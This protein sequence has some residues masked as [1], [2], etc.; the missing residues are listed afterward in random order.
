MTIVIHRGFLAGFSVIV[1][2][3]GTTMGGIQEHNPFTFE[4]VWAMFQET[5]KQS[6]ETDRKFKE[7]D[8]KFQETDKKFRETAERFRETDKKFKETDKKF[9]EAAE[10]FRETDRV[11]RETSRE[12]K[13][14]SRRLE[15]SKRDLD[16]RMGDLGNRFGE[17]AEHLVAPSI[18]EKFNALGYHFD[19]I[20]PGGLVI[21]D[22]ATKQSL[23]EI[24]ILLQNTE[25][26]VAVEVKAKLLQ[27]HV[28][29]HV[30]RV[31]ALRAWA[32]GHNDRRRIHGAVAGAIVN[33]G[34]RGYA[35]RAGFYVIVQT[36]DTVKID[37]PE[38]FIPRQW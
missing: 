22:L 18:N 19:A 15:E 3:G 28:D 11:V 29:D 35:L 7:T 14:M 21:E 13:E 25:T 38:G 1:G 37:V 10:S 26:M 8:K 34:V 33:A 4:A 16:R 27:R 32:D 24:D 12:I 9:R 30:R 5:G 23:A 31:G 17:L 2:Q 20:S 36:G 6:R